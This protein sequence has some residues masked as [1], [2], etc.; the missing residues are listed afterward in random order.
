[1]RAEDQTH[2]VPAAGTSRVRTGSGPAKCSGVGC[3]NT[4]HTKPGGRPR[5]WCSDRCRKLTLYSKSCA[6]CGGVCNT[7][8]SVT[9]ASVRCGTCH[10]KAMSS[11]GAR[12]QMS[13]RLRGVDVWPL[14]QIHKAMRSVA[15]DGYLT[16][17]LYAA[18]YNDAPR[19]SMPSLPTITLR[20]DGKWNDA[21][22]AAGLHGA[23][24][25]RTYHR[26]S[27][28]GCLLAVMDC[29]AD[30]DKLPTVPEYQAWRERTGAGPSDTIVRMRCGGWM[31]AIKD[32]AAD[33][34]FGLQEAA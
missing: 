24:A 22:I 10:R 30:I 21:L 13:A 17:T 14:D 20:Y 16:V 1:M 3:N 34:R 7:D 6:D 4:L 29:I 12:E 27:R 31:T 23:G 19:G 18:A 11:M 26:I 32:A 28:E 2:P 25:H 8:G 9:E 5:K 33:M 15:V